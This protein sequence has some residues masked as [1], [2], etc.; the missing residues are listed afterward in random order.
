[1]EFAQYKLINYYYLLLLL[2]LTDQL[3]CSSSSLD[4]GYTDAKVGEI[5]DIEPYIDLSLKWTKSRL[6][7]VS[8]PT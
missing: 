1:M 5:R 2:L 8:S 4:G 6:S 7:K 3:W